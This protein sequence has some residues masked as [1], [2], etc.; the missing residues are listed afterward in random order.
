MQFLT[1]DEQIARISPRSVLISNTTASST[2]ITA[3]PSAP[4]PTDTGGCT[5]SFS[6]SVPLY[7][8]GSTILPPYT[9]GGPSQTVPCD[10]FLAYAYTYAQTHINS[11]SST[12][13]IAA[14]STACSDC[15]SLYT[16][17][18]T[19][20]SETT[21]I[22][23]LDAA[24]GTDVYLTFTDA[25][26]FTT[27]LTVAYEQTTVSTESYPL[28]IETITVTGA[29]ET[30]VVAGDHDSSPNV[31]LTGPHTYTITT[32]EYNS[33]DTTW[34]QV[35][36]QTYT[37]TISVGIGAELLE[38]ASGSTYF[39]TTIQG[40]TV[41]II[42]VTE[43]W[44]G[45]HRPVMAGFNSSDPHCQAITNGLSTRTAWAEHFATFKTVV[46]QVTDDSIV[47]T[48]VTEGGYYSL[49]ATTLDLTLTGPTVYYRTLQQPRK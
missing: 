43:P 14:A 26:T 42:T 37:A 39:E 8:S 4:S 28:I 41:E 3:A 9:S 13:I 5:F 31:T 35:G 27:A 29:V 10:E 6:G 33:W 22:V 47:T 30:F 49:N 17:T 19:V 12:S 21:A 2:S 36:D 16:Y 18:L 7:T 11:S 24:Y 38:V 15:P 45:Y 40:P 34:K 32:K 1:S 48:R 44:P 25:T 20:P 46:A 23:D